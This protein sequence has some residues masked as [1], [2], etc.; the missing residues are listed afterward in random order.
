MHKYQEKCDVSIID[1]FGLYTTFKVT[2]ISIPH[3]VIKMDHSQFLHF[4]LVTEYLVK[5]HN[6][7]G[8]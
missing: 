8:N 3:N 1:P 5:K 6:N 4:T 2:C 7:Y